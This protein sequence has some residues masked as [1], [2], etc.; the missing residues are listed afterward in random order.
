ML[1]RMGVSGAKAVLPGMG[2]ETPARTP[3]PPRGP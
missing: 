1:A 3:P 2:L